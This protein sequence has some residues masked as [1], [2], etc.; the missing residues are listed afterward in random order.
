[1]NQTR[2]TQAQRRAE[3]YQQVLDS[4]C[5]LFAKKGFAGTSLEDIASDCGLTTRPVYHYFGNKLKLF[6]AVFDQMMVN[7]LE[8]LESVETSDPASRLSQHWNTFLDMSDDSG[9]RQIVL[10]DGP[11]ILGHEK[12]INSLVTEKA[13]ELFGSMPAASE[14]EKIQQQLFG[15][16]VIGA[17][18]QAALMVAESEDRELAKKLAI[19]LVNNMLTS[20]SNTAKQ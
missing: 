15:R 11:N 7:I 14:E 1:M 8:S 9:F 4:A 5:R 12:W 2:R 19:K 16:M 6:N 18:A 13:H 10:V 17:L 3:T 20:G